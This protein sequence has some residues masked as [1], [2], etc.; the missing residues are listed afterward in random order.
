VRTTTDT[1]PECGRPVPADS[2]TLGLC[3]RCLIRGVMSTGAGNGLNGGPGSSG[4][5]GRPAASRRP[6]SFVEP[7]VAEL[8]LRLPTLRVVRLIGRGG[9]GAVYEAIQPALARTVAV[10]VVPL[11]ALDAD[12]AD[13]E[14]A[15][16]QFRL[17]A[18][19]LARLN[20]PNV[21][22]VHDT[23]RV[24]ALAYFVMEHV[25]GHSLR[26]RLAGGP[27]PLADALT[28][29][30]QVCDALGYA[31]RRGVVHRDVKPENILLLRADDGRLVAKVADFG[32][33]K[34][35]HA[36]GV[37]PLTGL[38]AA[39]GPAAAGRAD[40]G[41]GWPPAP[42]GGPWASAAYP[43]G[44]L[45]LPAGRM[46]TPAYAAPEQ[47]AGRPADER[48][49]LYALGVVLYEMLCGRRPPPPGAAAADAGVAPGDR[50]TIGDDLPGPTSLMPAP[51]PLAVAA[52][53]DA[54]VLRCLAVDPAD[55]F[56][57]ADDLRLA[58]DEAEP[59][60]RDRADRPAARPGRT[61][62]LVVAAGLTAVALLPVAFAVGR[63]GWP[64]WSSPDSSSVVASTPPRVPIGRTGADPGVVVGGGGVSTRPAD[65]RF[66]AVASSPT[67]YA[68]ASASA[69]PGGQAYVSAH[70]G[71]A[72]GG[73]SPRRTA[74][75]EVRIPTTLP[76]TTPA[77]GDP[78]D[79]L[80]ARF[81][82][83]NVLTVKV[84]GVP[85]EMSGFV[86]D[87]V[88]RAAGVAGRRI[89]A[90]DG[91]LLVY[92]APA[93]DTALVA[94]SLK[95]GAVS[96]VDPAANAF[97]VTADPSLLPKPLGPPVNDPADP[98]YVEQAVAEL[99]GWDAA[100]RQSAVSKVR[101]LD[102][103]KYPP[104][105]RAAVAAALRP[106]ASGTDAWPAQTAVAA[107]AS[108]GSADDVPLLERVLD[109]RD[110]FTRRN[111]IEALGKIGGP[112][113]VGALVDRLADGADAMPVARALTAVGP[114]AEPE[115]LK[116][117]AG[118]SADSRVRAGLLRVLGAVGT[119]TCVP[120]LEAAAMDADGFV[121][122]EAAA[123]LAAVRRRAG[124]T[125]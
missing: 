73:G 3:P 53:L 88:Q 93:T 11:D 103:S 60:D 52:R 65:D 83:S 111:A 101:R 64:P 45:S 75:A 63:N 119:A 17:E 69:P 105:T 55:R 68:E 1:C 38:P 44:L 32:L 99:T 19:T 102:G 20:H 49:D 74:S 12:F 6:G 10:K 7:T 26:H 59:A 108:W 123:A 96:A 90:R 120:A 31:H 72:P 67:G 37:D 13:R 4:P 33:A 125:R 107:L 106:L 21:V 66:V 25:P 47:S 62:L 9:M 109:N 98:R 79:Q 14:A 92:V 113:A 30:R 87:R 94:R 41:R 2:R 16:E 86:A 5:A 82:R 95:L 61:A 89:G 39:G 100:R 84:I 8:A 104:Q 80:A 81:G 124:G 97:T 112:R 29:A 78:F 28:V 56:S 27:L 35:T 51:P 77:G 110:T 117:L 71:A 115:L 85:L 122:A 76:A 18:R 24:D 46:G 48:A 22:A 15:A 50:A 70:V 57:S 42:P 36:D 121:R 23:G 40:D 58:L 34:L 54:A 91:S 116:R 43:D 114:A 118:L